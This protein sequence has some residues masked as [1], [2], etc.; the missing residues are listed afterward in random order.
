M[1]SYLLPLG[2]AIDKIKKTK[3]NKQNKAFQQFAVSKKLRKQNFFLV[4]L[5][6]SHKL[7]EFSHD[8]IPLLCSVKHEPTASTDLPIPIFYLI[9]QPRSSSWTLPLLGTGFL[10]LLLLNIECFDVLIHRKRPKT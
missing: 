1:H 10:L 9:S 8:N 2:E 3:K 5:E 7:S 6:C 4:F